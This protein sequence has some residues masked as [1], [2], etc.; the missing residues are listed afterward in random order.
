MIPARAPAN[1]HESSP[2]SGVDALN[3]PLQDAAPDFVLA[4]LILDA[5]IEIGIV[6]DLDH[7]DRIAGLLDV[8]AVKAMADRARRAQGDIDY[9]RR[10]LGQSKG[11]IAPFPGAVRP[12]F[13]DLSMAARHP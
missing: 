3:E 13:D 2:R 7:G 11:A 5:M 1:P 12:M 10:R 4:D 9:P 8:D 6:V